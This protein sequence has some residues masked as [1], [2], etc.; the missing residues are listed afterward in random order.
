[1]L[2]LFWG[3]VS[4]EKQRQQRGAYRCFE[5]PASHLPEILKVLGSEP[6]PPSYPT[7]FNHITATP[8]C[9]QDSETS[10]SDDACFMKILD[11]LCFVNSSLG[12]RKKKCLS[13]PWYNLVCLHTPSDV[14]KEPHRHKEPAGQ[15]RMTFSLLKFQERNHSSRTVIPTISVFPILNA[16]ILCPFICDYKSY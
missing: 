8:W 2:F 7:L 11:L 14:L 13:L 12:P 9:R 6:H 1:M 5:A 10:L 16:K 3:N 15:C 4:S